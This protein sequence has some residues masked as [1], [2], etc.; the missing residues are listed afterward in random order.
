MPAPSLRKALPAVQSDPPPRWGRKDEAQVNVPFDGIA[1]LHGVSVQVAPVLEANL[2][3][4]KVTHTLT[5]QGQ[6]IQKYA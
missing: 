3:H 4:Y 1:S 6:N 5:L 2:L